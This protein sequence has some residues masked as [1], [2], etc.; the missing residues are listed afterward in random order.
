MERPG[1]DSEMLLAAVNKAYR[2]MLERKARLGQKVYTDD[3][4]GVMRTQRAIDVY[5]RVYG[6]L[7]PLDN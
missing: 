7:P 3:G 5:R 6:E 2:Q 1:T 4:T